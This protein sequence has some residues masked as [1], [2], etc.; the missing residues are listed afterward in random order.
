LI[1]RIAKRRAQLLYGVIH[2]VFE[3]DESIGWPQASAQF[4][5]SDHFSGMLQKDG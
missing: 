1:R 3:V 4:F 2:A 5:A